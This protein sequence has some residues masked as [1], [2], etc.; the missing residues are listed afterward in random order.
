MGRPRLL[1]ASLLVLA[2]AAVARPE[3]GSGRR[4]SPST[5]PATWS[6]RTPATGCAR[7]G[8]S[9]VSCTLRAAIQE[10]NALPGPD[11]I[12]VEPGIY[13]LEIPALND[14]LPDTG[15]YDIYSAVTIVG[16]G[17]GETIIDGGFPLEGSPI[18]QKGMDRLFEIHPTAKNVTFSG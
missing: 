2:I 15:D 8:F 17:P 18:E 14:D 9:G 12:Q 5:T 10:A 3:P 16:V 13:E 6:T 4:R 7:A 11:T 1:L